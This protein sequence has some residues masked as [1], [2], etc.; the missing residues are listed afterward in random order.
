M[1]NPLWNLILKLSSA[2]AALFL[3]CAAALLFAA[4]FGLTQNHTA[5]LSTLVFA[6]VIA[7]FSLLAVNM[8]HSHLTREIETNDDAAHRL[9]LGQLLGDADASRVMGSLMDVST[10][11]AERSSH[12][13]KVETGDLSANV[14]LRSDADVLGMALQDMTE[15]LREIVGTEATRD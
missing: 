2:A 9:S 4:N 13:M 3:L 7:L 14:S 15:K 11:L 8:S 5:G 1:Q 12:V 6:V 10:Y